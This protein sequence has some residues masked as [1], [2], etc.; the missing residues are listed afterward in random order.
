MDNYKEGTCGACG[1]PIIGDCIRA[2]GMQWHLDHLV[3]NVCHNDFSNGTPVW[4]GN[5]GYAYCPEHWKK[6]F[7]P[8]CATCKETILG[9]TINAL[10]KSYHPEHFICDVCKQKIDGQFFPSK[11]GNP[12]CEKDYYDQI[13]MRAFFSIQICCLFPFS[14]FFCYGFFL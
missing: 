13:G 14:N 7:C 8:V 5:D 10:N 6:T 3:C 1:E 11:E 9:P 2:F 12:L 4:E